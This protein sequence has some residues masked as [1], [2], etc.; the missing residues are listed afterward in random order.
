MTKKHVMRSELEAMREPGNALFVA[1]L[2]PDADPETILGIRIPL[3]RKLAKQIMREKN[4]DRFMD[5]LPHRYLEE[6]LIHVFLINEIKDY[7]TCMKRLEEFLPYLDCWNVTDS[8]RPKGIAA[9]TAETE[10]VLE[11]WLNSSEPFIVRTAIGLYMAF[12]LGS[13][14]RK[15]QA[16]RIA[17]LRF[18]HY[19]V[20]MMAAWYM[21]TALVKQPDAVMPL[22][23]ENRMDVWTH[24]K[25]IQKAAESYR[26][27]EEQKAYLKTLRRKGE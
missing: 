1:K 7:D 12:Y 15:E 17:A 14:F 13:A 16:E 27:T 20:R 23:E 4:A 18:D 22:F 26:V 11:A 8:V 6:N 9:H 25:A 21:A 3:L 5:D 10:P 2:M 24:N 19:Y